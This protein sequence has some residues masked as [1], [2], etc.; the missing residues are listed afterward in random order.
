MLTIW[1]LQ[2]T[3]G[4]RSRHH[5]STPVMMRERT[6]RRTQPPGRDEEPASRRR[7][8]DAWRLRASG[9]FAGPTGLFNAAARKSARAAEWQTSSRHH[10]WLMQTRAREV[11]TEVGE[12]VSGLTLR[13]ASH[14]TRNGWEES[15]GRSYWPGS[16]QGRQLAKRPRPPQPWTMLL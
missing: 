3:L 9:W 4:V 7:K 14:R 15:S 8:G 13:I 6:C 10:M 12:Q 11:V 5:N 16:Q 2:I 1:D